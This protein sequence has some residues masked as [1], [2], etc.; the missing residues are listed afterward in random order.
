MTPVGKPEAVI[1][2]LP[3]KPAEGV[4]VIVFVPVEP[5]TTVALLAE[6]VK[7]GVV[8]PEPLEGASVN[9]DWK[10][11]LPLVALPELAVRAVR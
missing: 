3:V 11:P 2:M 1:A 7:L 6:K 5:A 10:M 8:V 9:C 4:T